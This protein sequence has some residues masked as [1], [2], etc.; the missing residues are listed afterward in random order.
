MSMLV[1]CALRVF[2]IHPVDSLFKIGRAT[3]GLYASASESSMLAASGWSVFQN[4]D[5]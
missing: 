3:F 1:G 2:Q 5:A 4:L